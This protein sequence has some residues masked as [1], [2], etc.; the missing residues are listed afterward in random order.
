MVY[1]KKRGN[2]SNFVEF[3]SLNLKII[4]YFA[5]FHNFNR[6]GKFKKIGHFWGFWKILWES[7]FFFEL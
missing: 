3:S 1:G 2:Y 4:H 5:D 6:F 7:I